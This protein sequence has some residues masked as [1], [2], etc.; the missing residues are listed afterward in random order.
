MIFELRWLL[1]A[2]RLWMLTARLPETNKQ[3]H[4]KMDGW[5]MNFLL[6]WPIFRG[7]VSFRECSSLQFSLAKANPILQQ[8][9]GP[10]DR[11]FIDS[12]L[13]E[14]NSPMFVGA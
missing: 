4:L 7:Y 1:Q 12:S 9:R 14:V 6:G 3:K 5:K 11:D 8:G 10:L 2:P 13:P